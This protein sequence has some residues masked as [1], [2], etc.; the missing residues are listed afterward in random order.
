MFSIVV[1]SKLFG[2]RLHDLI[3]INLKVQD[4]SNKLVLSS[5]DLEVLDLVQP[6]DNRLYTVATRV[7]DKFI[8][9]YGDEFENEL[10]KYS[11]CQHFINDF[12]TNQNNLNVTKIFLDYFHF[13]AQK[14]DIMK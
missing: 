13:Q 6:Y 1:F 3:G 8:R 7:L 9:G 10:V 4:Y 12:C 5:S 14:G 11:R 2:I